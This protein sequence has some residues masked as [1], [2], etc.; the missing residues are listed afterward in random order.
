MKA[1]CS[2]W[3]QCLYM[4]TSSS[5]TTF[6]PWLV[7]LTTR[8]VNR[9]SRCIVVD[10]TQYQIYTLEPNHL[11]YAPKVLEICAGDIIV[12]GFNNICL[13]PQ[14]FVS[15]VRFRHSRWWLKN[16]LLIFPTSPH[17]VKQYFSFHSELTFSSNGANAYQCLR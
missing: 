8:L 5:Y 9:N 11:V 17:V 2:T 3:E 10:T 4:A 1:C 15:R 12:V 16:K 13:L 7:Q 6:H 14:E